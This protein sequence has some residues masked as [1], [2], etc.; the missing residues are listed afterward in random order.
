MTDILLLRKKLYQIYCLYV[1]VLLKYQAV[2]TNFCK[3]YYKFSNRFSLKYFTRFY[4]Q[5]F[6]NRM[7]SQ[8]DLFILIFYT[9]QLSKSYKLLPYLNFIKILMIVNIL[10]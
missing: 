5:I 3:P 8:K 4:F 10:S 9:T 7:F 6:L 2:K 1:F